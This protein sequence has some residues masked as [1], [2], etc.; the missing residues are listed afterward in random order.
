MYQVSKKVKKQKKV[1]E[2]STSKKKSFTLPFQKVQAVEQ[3]LFARHLALMLKAGLPLWEGIQTLRDQAKDKHF[4]RILDQV[5]ID[6]NQGSSLAEAL[7]KFP[8]DFTDLFVNMIRIGEESG[9]LEENLNH[10]AEQLGKAEK[11]KKSVKSAMMYPAIIVIAAFGIGFVMAFFILPKLVAFLKGLNIALPLATRI[12]LAVADFGQ[13][14]GYVF[15]IAPIVFVILFR[16]LLKI[17]SFKYAI[18]SLLLRLPI[19]GKI[20]KKLNMAY[21]SRTL[22][23]L[24][25]SGVTIVDAINT[26]SDV[27]RNL[28]YRDIYT[29]IATKVRSGGTI[30]GI[31]VTKDTLFPLVGARMI[32]IGE[33]TG[34]LEETLLYLAD[35]YEDEVNEQLNSLSTIIEPILLIA[36]GLGVAFVA[37]AIITP[38]YGITQGLQLG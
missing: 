9:S 11:L 8:R 38:I 23:T 20:I 4:K 17:R 26:T 36:I 33:R 16:L 5:L 10:L 37:L 28:V 14:Y 2:S 29:S 35:Y 24:L 21:F 27:T 15:I 3:I 25:R 12:L 32:E 31:L 18:H 7:Q 19:A 30:A 22:G 34:S 1:P 6:V 13:D